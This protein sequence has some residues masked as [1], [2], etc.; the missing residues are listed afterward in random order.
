MAHER[1]KIIG[2]GGAGCKAVDYSIRLGVE[3]MDTLSIDTDSERIKK[4]LSSGKLLIDL[5]SSD[6]SQLADAG[7][8]AVIKAKGETTAYLKGCSMIILAAAM[9]GGFESGA[10]TAIADMAGEMGILV[11]A[12]A[13]EDTEAQSCE[14]IE[15]LRKSDAAVLTVP[16]N[17]HNS[18]GEL[19]DTLYNAIQVVI[20]ISAANGIVTLD[21]D[22]IKHILEN[23][24]HVKIGIGIAKAEEN[25][26]LKE[27][28]EGAAGDALKNA[29]V[30]NSDIKKA[31]IYV[32]NSPSILGS[33]L[34]L[35]D[36]MA[37]ISVLQGSMNEDA[38]IFWG[39][40]FDESMNDSIKIMLLAVEG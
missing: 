10:T 22:D 34:G 25:S 2:V 7:K 18:S 8:K 29:L 12:V 15:M 19:D 20:N 23:S 40:T 31:L 26:S 35:S 21:F 30:Q 5:S 1:I 36:L 28:A 4:S 24:G 11:L 13:A 37:A 39:H 6:L 9:E 14:A 27:L 32:S 38:E 16:F 33:D 17:P 3:A